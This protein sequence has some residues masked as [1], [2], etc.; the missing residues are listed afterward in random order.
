MHPFGHGPRGD[1]L[2]FVPF[3]GLLALALFVFALLALAHL[4]RSGKLDLARFG[5]PRPEEEAKRVLAE[6]FAKGDLSPEEFLER[7]SIL[8][9]TPGVDPAAAGSRRL[10]RR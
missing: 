6:R 7:S 10:R 8:N 5:R 4:V 9:W 1:E 3:L 2:F